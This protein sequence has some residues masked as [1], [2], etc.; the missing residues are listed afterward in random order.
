M[1]SPRVIPIIALALLLDF[2]PATDAAPVRISFLS[3]PAALQD[4]LT[5]LRNGGC[6]PESLRIFQ[7]AVERYASSPV[8]FDFNKFPKPRDGFYSFMSAPALVAALPQ[9]L[10]ETPHAYELNC[11]DTVIA[12]TGDSLRTS[13]RPDDLA[14]PFWVPFTRTNGYF[15][16]LPRATA[17][18]AFELAY[19]DWYRAA[20]DKSL[21]K[22]RDELRIALTAALFRCHLLPQSTTE[23]GLKN[24]VMAAL[25]AS[26][27]RDKMVFPGQYE[28]VLGHQVSFPQR[29]FVTV[30]AGLL[31]SHKDGFTYV[32]KAGGSGPFVRL[33]FAERTDLL[34]WLGGMFRG[35]ERLGYTHH[36]ATFNDKKVETLEIPRR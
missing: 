22:S 15:T 8:D 9:P 3:E 16:I 2:H 27:E 19:P 34:V 13:V 17:R 18:E 7:H 29:W 5:V 30:H 24:A 26:W 28:V 1:P 31:I 36:F 4:T 25:R 32:E 10:C 6:Q 14:S 21:P 33:D 35:A 12:L 11:F 20:T 23:T